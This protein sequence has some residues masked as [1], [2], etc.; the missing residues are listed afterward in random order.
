MSEVQERTTGARRRYPRIDLPKGMM[1]AWQGGADRRSGR[2][3]TLSLGGIFIRT[4]NPS[5]AGTLLQMVFEVPG[6]D[7]HARGAVVY[8]QPGK[9]MGIQ[10]RGMGAEQ[11]A[12]LAHLL[13]RLLQ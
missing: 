5:L 3:A 12:R 8:V 7:V 4:P 10:F 6:G 9:G 2:I 1:V 13:K 11:R